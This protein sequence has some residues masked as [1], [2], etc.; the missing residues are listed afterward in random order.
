MPETAGA[1]FSGSTL[2]DERLAFLRQALEKLG[3]PFAA[4][5]PT[6]L[7][8]QLSKYMLT[9][10]TDDLEPVG[11][12][13]GSLPESGGEIPAV[14]GAYSTRM[15]MLDPQLALELLASIKGQAPDRRRVSASAGRL[16]WMRCRAA[17]PCRKQ[18]GSAMRIRNC[19]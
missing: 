16:F 13:L 14:L 10:S 11:R 3:Q 4:E 7:G 6:K 15:A 17:R 2:P 19:G 8:I 9:L 12:L 5:E 18:C 1:K